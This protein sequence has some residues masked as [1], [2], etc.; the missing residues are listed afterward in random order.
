MILKFMYLPRH[1]EMKTKSKIN[2]GLF[3]FISILIVSI[4]FTILYWKKISFYFSGNSKLK[5]TRVEEQI[6]PYLEKGKIPKNLISDFK[7]IANFYFESSYTNSSANFFLAKSNYY[8]I[9]N[10]L[11][12]TNLEII[13][14]NSLNKTLKFIENPKL[15]LEF[16][17]MY[18]KALRAKAFSEDF[19]EKEQNQILILL[20]ESIVLKNLTEDSF[21]KINYDKIPKDLKKIYIILSFFSIPTTGQIDKLEKIFQLNE[22][23]K[24]IFL[25]DE[26]KKFLKAVC[27]FQNK[28][29]IK[30]LELF[31]E[32]KI[33]LNQI[34]IEATRY[35]AEIFSKQNLPEKA[36]SILEELY[37]NTGSNNDKIILQIKEILKTKNGLKTKL[38][39]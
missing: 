12:L 35:E 36:I 19:A 3:F 38:D 25:S 11:K 39:I 16:D 14:I 18:K 31:R 9:F 10:S 4:F 17:E 28:D 5:V 33:E 15:K 8:E 1:Y 2:F 6:I 29:L 26:E 30:S 37:S 13:Q 34:G 21:E 22:T 7:T 24:L 23:E 32:A 20:Y 27:F